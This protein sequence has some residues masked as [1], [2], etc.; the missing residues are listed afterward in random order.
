MRRL[1]A[2]LLLLAAPAAAQE[3]WPTQPVRLIVPFA[4]GGQTDIASRILAEHMGRAHGQRF[5][6]ENRTGAGVVVG[7]EVAA[8]AA[9]DGHALLYT[10]I[11]HAV[12]KPLVARLPFDPDA[13]FAPVIHVGAVPNAM[14]VA[15]D[16]PAATLAEFIALLRAN[17]NTYDAAFSGVGSATHLALA[18]F[19]AM[20]NVEFTMVP[21]RGSGAIYP[22]LAA[23]RVHFAAPVGLTLARDPALRTLAVTTARRAKTLPDVPTVAEAGLPGYEAYSWHMVFAPRAT[24]APLVAR[25]NAAITAALADPDVARRM[26]DAEMELDPGTPAQAAALLARESAKW[27]DI[28]RRIGAVPQ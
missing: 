15:R 21:Y 8:R 3:A 2:A 19:G 17:P 27:A 9:P 20:A 6:V 10:T 12:L 4:A 13:D 26:A 28:L 16:V 11:A 18:L 23:G 22:D 5:V 14:V 24:P 25:I 7:T 1:L